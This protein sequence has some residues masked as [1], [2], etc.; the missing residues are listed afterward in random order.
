MKQRKTR[1]RRKP[2]FFYYP[3]LPFIEPLLPHEG[4]EKVHILQC[5]T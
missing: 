1:G 4:I 5:L 2:P 3:S